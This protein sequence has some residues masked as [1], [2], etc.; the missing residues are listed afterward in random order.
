[1]SVNNAN[2]NE[3][4]GYGNTKNITPN[5]K[6]RGNMFLLTLNEI[7]K[8]EELKDALCSYSTLKYFISCIETAPTT[9]HKHIHIFVKFSQ[10]KTLWA[11]KLC[12]ANIIRCNHLE[13]A[14]N[15][16]KKDG[17]ILDELGE[18]RQRGGISGLTIKQLK[19]MS[20]EE[21][22]E[23][24][25]IYYNII[26]KIKYERMNTINVD[27]IYID[28]KEVIYIYGK[29]GSGKSRNAY[30]MIKDKGYN[31][32][33]NVK[34]QN[35][36]WIGMNGNSECAIYDDFR[37]SDMKVNEFLHFI[38]YNKHALNIKGGHIIC[39]YKLIIITSIIPPDRIYR[40]KTEEEQKQW[41]R[42]M[43][44]FECDEKGELTE[45]IDDL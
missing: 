5:F 32:F 13:E 14:I 31:T 35:S 22:D 36:F 43:R 33:E 2:E 40:N 18:I 10:L 26:Q 24:P 7:E 17:D 3:N 8:Y 34:Y 16:V 9:G 21:L 29:S 44:I 27:D 42:R 28:N 12:N 1:M 39:N 45:I 19:T 4:L 25:P 15:Y 20:N 38:D 23:L 30:K 11:K 6:I 41:L 37:D